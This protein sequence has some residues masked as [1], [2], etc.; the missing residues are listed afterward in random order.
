MGVSSFS[1]MCSLSGG[2]DQWQ[3]RG[4]C[5]LL[6]GHLPCALRLLDQVSLCIP[7]EDLLLSV[8]GVLILGWLAQV[9]DCACWTL[10]AIGVEE[11]L[12]GGRHSNKHLGACLSVP[13]LLLAH[14]LLPRPAIVSR[15]ILP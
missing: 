1:V 13:G 8:V 5:Q 12:V 10:L 6:L 2:G 14:L 11:G 3:V 7:R 15:E 9:V 4:R